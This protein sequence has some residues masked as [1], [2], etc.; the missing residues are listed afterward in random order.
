MKQRFRQLATW[1]ITLT[2]LA[3]TGWAAA[4]EPIERVDVP[5]QVV[6]APGGSTTFAIK[7]KVSDSWHINQNPPEPKFM[8]PTKVRIS[9]SDDIEIEKVDYPKGKPFKVEGFDEPVFVYTGE[10]EITVH[11]KA[12]KTVVGEGKVELRLDYQ[13]CDDKQCKPPA[14]KTFELPIVIADRD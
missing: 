12:K 6:V 11:V 7:I 4:P 5:K 14:K 8:I 1:T 13:A 10:V 9:D 3:A 2:L